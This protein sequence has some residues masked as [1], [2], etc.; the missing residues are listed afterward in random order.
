MVDTYN[1]FILGYVVIFGLLVAYCFY[2]AL[3][4]KKM[5]RKKTEDN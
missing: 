1:Y 5:K 2:L 3:V 4:A